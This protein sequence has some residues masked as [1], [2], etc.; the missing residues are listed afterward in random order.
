MIPLRYHLRSLFERRAM[1]GTAALGVALSVLV[2]GMVVALR[3]GLAAALGRSGAMD[4]AMVL[5]AGSEAELTSQFPAAD[6]ARVLVAPSIQAGPDGQPLAEAEVVVTM[7]FDRAGGD[8]I[9]S[10]VL[11]G[12]GPRSLALR[13][14]LRIA[15][16][17]A[18]APGADEAMI[19]SALV[20]RFAGLRLGGQ[21]PLGLRPLTVVGVLDARGGV[22][23]SE[24][25][26]DRDA[27]QRATGR[28]ALMSSVRVRLRAPSEL[29][30]LRSRVEQDRSLELH[31]ESEP[32]YFERQRDRSAAFVLG[33]G[34]LVCAGFALA[35]LLGAAVTL[36]A[37]VAGRK[38]EIGVLRALG[39]S[40]S[41]VLAS[42]LLESVMVSLAG[43]ALG[44][45]GA[46]ALSGLELSL[47]NPANFS[48]VVFSLEPSLGMLGGAG[49]MALGMGLCGG[50]VPA[51]RAARTRPAEAIRD[52]D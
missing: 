19:G 50:L 6:V 29:E 43:G 4:V 39:F 46:L 49:A 12:I 2:L 40:A 41:Q 30:P 52:R 51:L 26:A 3:T 23:D 1:A 9:S 28:E 7:S 14:G 18:P 16:G 24:I 44:I 36:H 38:T 31:V 21:L 47:V 17:R 22:V 20:G 27:V 5:R 35:A 45:A 33:I 48:E 8:G 32:A 10:L 15:Q 37:L 25:W 13:A 11:R 42:F 34:T